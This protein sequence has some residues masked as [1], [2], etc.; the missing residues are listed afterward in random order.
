MPVLRVTGVLD[1]G[2]L[3]GSKA[4]VNPRIEMRVIQGSSTTIEMQVLTPAGKPVD[5][6]S[7]TVTLTVKK[8]TGHAAAVL[9]VTGTLAQDKGLGRVDF[10]IAPSATKNVAP[11]RYLYDVWH[12]A[13]STR[14][15]VVPTSPFAL[16]PAV[17]LP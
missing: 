17:L 1:D 2:S 16:E 7:S 13:G 3:Q 14:E 8:K 6:T 5:L 9:S 11:G 10:S 12:V 15:P 4:P